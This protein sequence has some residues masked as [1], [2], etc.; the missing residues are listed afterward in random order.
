MRYR[1][2]TILMSV[3]FWVCGAA[4][5]FAQSCTV[6]P[7]SLNFGSIVTLS[8]GNTDISGTITLSCP[9]LALGSF[10]AVVSADIGTGGSSGTVRQMA[11]GSSRLNYQLYRDPA[12]T[13]VFSSNGSPLGGGPIERSGSSLLFG[14]SVDIPFYGRVFGNQSGVS[15]GSYASYVVI[16]VDYSNCGLLFCNDGTAFLILDV[17]AYVSKQCSVSA[18]DIN[19]GSRGALATNV[20]ANGR[21]DVLCTPGTDFAISLSNGQ[22]GTS[23]ND[24]KMRSPAGGTVDY[25]L[26]RTPDYT[27]VWGSSLSTDTLSGSGS[28]TTDAYTVFGRVPAQPTP[29]AGVYSDTIIV[30]LTY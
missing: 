8:S 3:S 28:G 18:S 12:R 17:V 15:S 16:R 4:Q 20:N 23:A 30:T 6:S 22:N 7:E 10:A 5:A 24:R 11:N 2:L 26:Y 27:A 19:F 1:I 13:S 29:A 14:S 9:S 25:N 21:L